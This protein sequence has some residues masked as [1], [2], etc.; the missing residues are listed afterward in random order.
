[1][2]KKRT[3]D[4]AQKRALGQVIRAARNSLGLTQEQLAELMGCSVRWLIEV[5]GG[6]SCFNCMDTIRLLAALGLDPIEVA[7]EVGIHVL[8]PA[9]RK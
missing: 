9:G 8:I 5:E 4:P 7:E 6:K 2:F 3:P 1:M